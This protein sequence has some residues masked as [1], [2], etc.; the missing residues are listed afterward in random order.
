MARIVWKKNSLKL[1]EEKKVEH[2]KKFNVIFNET[3]ILMKFE[4]IH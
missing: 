4:K 3:E 2:E 1:I